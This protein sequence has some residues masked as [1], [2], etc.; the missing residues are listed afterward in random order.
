MEGAGWTGAMQ[1]TLF[2]F[3]VFFTVQFS[4]IFTWRACDRQQT[5]HSERE[6]A[7][8]NAERNLLQTLFGIYFWLKCLATFS[9]RCG[10]I[11]ENAIENNSM[12]SMRF[13]CNSVNSVKRKWLHVEKL[14]TLG[15]LKSLHS[16]R[17][18]QLPKPPKWRNPTVLYSL[19]SISRYTKN[20]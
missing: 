17:D 19:R 9:I 10:N 12:L 13:H 5:E 15:R 14:K 20:I 2:Y 11:F 7:A 3:L 4:D 8:S 18:F 1:A 6:R 16:I